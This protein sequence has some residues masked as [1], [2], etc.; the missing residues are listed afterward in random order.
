MLNAE[1]QIWVNILLLLIGL[2]VIVKGA[3]K[4]VDSAVVIARRTRV[5][6]VII[7]ATIV[8]LGTTLPEF[9]VA[10]LGGIFDRPQTVMGGVIGSTIA[11]IGLV[12]GTCL[13]IRPIMVA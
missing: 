2:A 5:P 8:S 13:L 11:N 4:F 7:G 9:C 6:E 12:L 10:V 1:F 3:D